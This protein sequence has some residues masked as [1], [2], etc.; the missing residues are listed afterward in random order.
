MSFLGE[1]Q[2]MKIQLNFKTSCCNLKLRGLGA[3]LCVAFSIILI[4]KRN[5]DALKSKSPFILLNKDINFNKNGTDSK[6][7]DPTYSF[8][9]VNV[10]LQL[11]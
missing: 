10:A 1:L 11:I 2:L 6:M 5:Y 9:E 7:K 4:L 3:K 8:R